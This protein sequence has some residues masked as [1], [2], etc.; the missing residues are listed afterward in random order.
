MKRQVS[1]RI[2]GRMLANKNLLTVS[3][4]LFLSLATH[5]YACPDLGSSRTIFF[6]DL[7]PQIDASVAARVKIV[8]LLPIDRRHPGVRRAIAR[9]EKVVAG[10]IPSSTI[11]LV[12]SNYDCDQSPTIGASGLVLGNLRQV[13]PNEFELIAQSES[14][15]QKRARLNRR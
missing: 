4:V 14:L 3:L 8:R 12:S 1:A 11:T 5:A 7:P 6:D 15:D 10:T 2:V 9:V 13:A